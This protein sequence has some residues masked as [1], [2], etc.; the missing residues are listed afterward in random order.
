MANGYPISAIAGRRDIMKLM[1]EIFF[2]FTFGG[3]TLSI[4]AAIATLTK[5]QKEPVIQTLK[6]RGEFLMKEAQQLIQKYELQHVI[7]I[8]GHPSL[9]FL[10]FK[11][12]DCYS[13]WTLKTLWMQEIFKR[14]ILSLGGHNLSYAHSQKDI[15]KLI[16]VYDEVFFLMKQAI[17]KKQ[18]EKLLKCEV[19]KPLFRVR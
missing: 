14:G 13:Q 8:S 6:A 16:A 17:A 3:E 10:Q 15:A 7:V 19:L 18:V 9:I 4:A 5:I 2:S 12:T 1:E 11:D